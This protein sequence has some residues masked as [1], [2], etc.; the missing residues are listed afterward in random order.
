MTPSLTVDVRDMF[1]LQRNF[2]EY[3]K[4][5]KK[6]EDEILNKKGNDLRI[7]LFKGFWAQ[8][9]KK[10]NKGGAFKL[11]KALVAAGKGVYVRLMRLVEPWASQLPDKTKSGK[12]L[13]I[14]QKLVA[15]EMMRRQAGVGIL[16]VSFL[17]KRWA[18]RKESRYLTT[19]STRGFGKAVTFE[20]RDGEFIITGFTPGLARV[21]QKYG[22]INGAI[23]KVSADIETY[24][25]RKLGPEFVQTLHK[26]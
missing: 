19:N 18:Y 15:Q 11:L 14:R 22:I 9:W 24:L 3:V 10:G 12:P 20:K 2:K 13:N 6:S 5:Y 7:Q 21:A 8:R 4:V 25:A 26:P 17:R 16:G 23:R 1:R